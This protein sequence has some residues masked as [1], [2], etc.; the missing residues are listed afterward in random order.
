MK[1]NSIK[2]VL[3]K[4]KGTYGYD[5]WNN[6]TEKAGAFSSQAAKDDP[7]A[8]IMDMMKQ[9]ARFAL[10]LAFP[11]FSFSLLSFRCFL[12]C[13]HNCCHS[14]AAVSSIQLNSAFLHFRS[15]R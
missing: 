9:S 15:V 5:N 12:R 11:S 3:V 6:L 14:T 13:R 7:G 1:K 2:V 8:G 4:I 10:R